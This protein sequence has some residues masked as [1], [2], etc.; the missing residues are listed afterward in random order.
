MKHLIYISFLTLFVVFTSESIKAQNINILWFDASLQ[1]NAG[2]GISIITNPTDSFTVANR[3]TLELSDVGGTWTNPTILKDVTE[4]Y[5]PVFNATL[6]PMIVEG[7]YKMRIRSSN[8]VW[9]EETPSFDVKA[10]VAPKIPTLTS[11]LLNNTTYFNCQ[12]N[13]VG[14]LLFGSLNKEVGATTISMNAAQRLVKINDYI[15][16]DAYQVMLYDILNNNQIAASR[17]GNS[18]TLPDNL[19]LG[20]YVV[21]VVHTQGSSSVF[22]GVFLYHGNGT[23]L[24]NSSSEE[25][26][27]NN[28]VFFGV[29]T[30]NSGI[31]RN[32]AGSKYVVNFGD[33]SAPRTYTQRQ[34][35]I[36]SNIQHIF[37]KASCSETASSFN[38]NIQLWN[39]GIESNCNAF[40][41]NGKGVSKYI[42]VSVPPK[43]DFI[44]PAK[45]CINKEL[46][47][48]N[49]TLPGYYGRSNCKEGSNFY[50]YYQ[51][52]GESEYTTVTEASWVDDKGNLKIPASEVNVA[53]CWKVKIEAQNQDLCQAISE[54]AKT[55]MIESVAQA[56]FTASNDS[57]C[58]NNTVV[59]TNT[60]NVLNQMCSAPVY[61][62]IVEPANAQNSNGYSFITNL[63]N[64]AVK[65][66]K[67]G[68]YTVKLKIVNACGTI[69][70]Q[71]TSIYVAGSA[72]VSL[73]MDTITTC[74]PK[75]TT[76]KV[77]FTKKDLKPLYNANY[78]AIKGY[79]WTVKGENVNADDCQYL[80]NTSATSAFPVIDFK[81]SK[82]Y[83]VIVEVES[84]CF[85]AQA[86]TLIVNVN[87]TPEINVADSS[88]T[89]CS[90]TAFRKIDLGDA[91]YRWAVKTSK[92][93]VQTTIEGT[94]KSI[95]GQVFVNNSDSV[96]IATFSIIPTNGVCIGNEFIYKVYVK[97]SL[98]SFVTGVT[99]FCLGAEN[100]ELKI[101]CKNGVPPYTITYKTDN[102]S[103]QYATS[104]NV[105]DTVYIN[106]P[107]S[108]VGVQ[109]VQILNIDDT[110]FSTCNNVKIDTVKVEIVD[111]PIIT[112]QPTAEQTVCIGAEID[113]LRI[114]LA[115]NSSAQKIQW[116][117]NT[118]NSNYGGT[119]IQGANSMAFKPAAFSQKGDFYYYAL[120]TLNASDCG[121]ALS[122]VAHV[123]VVD[124]PAITKQ[125]NT[126]QSVCK[127]TILKPIEVQAQG[128]GGLTSYKWYV[129]TDTI[130]GSLTAIDGA[131]EAAY[132]PKSDVAGTFYYFCEV[133]QAGISCSTMSKVFAI[134][135]FDT[136]VISKEP[137]SQHV[138]KSESTYSLHVEYT[139]G[140]KL[141]SYQWFQ[142]STKSNTGGVAIQNAT[143]KTLTVNTGA[144]GNFY[145]YCQLTFGTEGCAMLTSN[146]AEISVIQFPIVGNQHIEVIS[147]NEFTMNPIATASDYLPENTKY[148]WSVATLPEG[149]PLSG[150]SAQTEAQSGITGK[151]TNASDTIASVRY[152]V[153]PEID[154]CTGAAFSLNVVVL[155]A[156]KVTVKKQDIL[157]FEDNNGQLEAT[158]IGGIRFASGNP[159]K[160]NWIGPDGFESS[161][162]RLTN[163][164]AGDY[165]LSVEDARG[166]EIVNKYIIERPEKLIIE[167]DKFQEI[168][169]S[170]E[171]TASVQVKISGGK[172][173]YSYRWTKNN[174]P[175]SETE[176]ITNLSK[177]S[178]MLTV[179]D[180][181]GCTATSE[182]YNI[183]EFE[184]IEIK[185]IEQVNNTCFGDANG[186]VKIEVTGGTKI[187]NSEVGYTFN[188]TGVKSFKSES[189]NVSNL[190]SGEYQLVVSDK[191]GCTA[192]LKLNISQPTEINIT[193]YVTPLSC[194]GRND[195]SIT[196][197]V[198]GGKAPYEIEWSNFATGFIQ[199]N[200]SPGTYTAKVT[201][202]NGCVKTIEVEIVD[203]SQFKVLPTVR[204]ISCNGANDGS[205]KL[206]I[207]SNRTGIKV[208]WLDGSKAGNERNNLA[209]GVYTVEVS[210]GGPCVL[211]NSFVISEPT[212]MY[213][214]SKIKN[215]FACETG[216][217]GAIE[218]KVTGGTAPYTYLWS[219]GQ[220]TSAINNLLPGKYFVTVTDSLGCNKIES[221]ELLRHEPLTVNVSSKI[222]YSNAEFKF[223]EICTANVSGG[224]APYSYSWSAGKIVSADSTVMESFVN[225]TISLEVVD[226]LGCT[227][228][229]YFKTNIPEANIET[230]VVDCNG[231]VYRFEIKTPTVVSSDAV[232][233]WD[234]GDGTSSNAKAPTHI[235]LQPGDFVVKLK[236]TTNDATMNFETTMNVEAT[237]KLKLDR[238]PRFCKNDSVE[239]IV[240]GADTY[241]WNDG[242]R[243]NRKVVRKEGTYSVLGTSVKGC[244]STLSFTAQHYDYQNYTISTDKNVLTL[245]D[246]TLKVWTEETNQ[247]SYTWQFGDS[248]MDEGNY[249]NHTYD[250]NSP[251]TVKVKLDVVNPYGCVE[252]AEKV[253]WLIMEEIPNTFTPNNDGA[254][255]KFL[256]GTKLQVFNSNGII[257]YEGTEGWDGTYKGKPVAMDTYYYVVYYSTPEGIVNKPG[258]VFLTK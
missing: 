81:P 37:T 98:R 30:S 175:Y 74:I 82:Q 237:P 11:T 95:E 207:K 148:T 43:A 79:K 12:D 215:S 223:K 110:Y 76:F 194:S 139:G 124:D 214:S 170:G 183:S 105:N 211:T 54:I 6:P 254:N 48:T 49:N 248:I 206:A 47:F 185:V 213:V 167:T 197:D 160:V 57:I 83:Q 60:S 21:Q 232:Y 244:S 187:E 203:D 229:N 112:Q 61:T 19:P 240:S 247:T 14:G 147:A 87:E 65:F 1:Y 174:V 200:L 4:F 245:N 58:V 10:G 118:K 179:T 146:V 96:G 172:G 106:I 90:G 136:P 104:G 181:N 163:L 159:Y 226:A 64:A 251:I 141:V 71:G 154:G 126:I 99:D 176:D 212:K 36:N 80:N 26:C 186:S 135:I 257:L 34:L 133:S 230:S 156:L 161:N 238:E 89:I 217:S 208:K 29:D 94:G 78:G 8:P 246:P 130:K 162:L 24:G 28:S 16:N 195:A 59:F 70:S 5:M 143:S 51:K 145:Y 192:T 201:D 25:I 155:P 165:T 122:D 131:I 108:K 93:L 189:Q 31:G 18:I 116:F 225:Q 255:D 169:C 97:P 68:V 53:G 7:K 3:F 198:T 39:K 180:E 91:I 182:V 20:T 114:V 191:N 216:A 149:S 142:N 128:N 218:I 45:G 152:I 188:W 9:V 236:I 196:L 210:D 221:F 157:C 115:S 101:V 134:E 184:P 33:G 228:T 132:L 88:Q 13:S 38:V 15:P 256:T 258:F 150:M 42:N 199:Q 100:A 84:D 241:I 69:T 111:N 102:G 109:D 17:N 137:L 107:T 62:W 219:N 220:T 140:G 23:N 144:A 127:N 224:L 138:C 153:V 209:P 117:S 233:T 41:K 2:S 50:W 239:L 129:T 27:V 234:F 227:I 92:N 75:N 193:S 250:I 164:T 190:L 158:I 243:G 231:Q 22:G 85:T 46:K 72:S 66:T 35:I 222:A 125:L 171:N 77:D 242:T 44:A 235:F 123:Q 151:I 55:V 253:V 166:V 40:T 168:N 249:V 252:T 202:A 103:L 86:D 173:K 32:Y 67:P 121:M 205:I 52:P 119:A 178:Y 56:S 204:Q 113:S 73:P 120:I 63:D 177:G